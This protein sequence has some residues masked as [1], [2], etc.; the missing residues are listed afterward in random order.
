VALA[1]YDILA[2]LPSGFAL[3]RH[4]FEA[5]RFFLECRLAPDDLPLRP[6]RRCCSG[7][8]PGRRRDDGRLDGMEFRRGRGRSAGGGASDRRLGAAAGVLPAPRPDGAHLACPGPEPDA[9]HRGDRPFRDRSGL[10]GNRVGWIW[11]GP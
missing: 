1:V 10:D 8:R 11:V 4:R 5:G 9:R 3:V 2:L 7:P 6:R